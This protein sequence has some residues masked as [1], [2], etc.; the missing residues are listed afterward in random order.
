[1]AVD[2]DRAAVRLVKL[3]YQNGLDSVLDIRDAERTLHQ[4]ERLLADSTTAVS[5]RGAAVYKALGGG[6]DGAAGCAS[7]T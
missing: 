4:I 3:S 5:M 6:C 1:M 2:Q 7:G